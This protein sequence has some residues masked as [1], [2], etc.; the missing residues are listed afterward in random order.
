MLLPVENQMLVY[1]VA[2]Y[3]NGFIADDGC[4]LPPVSIAEYLSRRVLGRIDDDKPRTRAYEGFNGRPVGPKIRRQQFVRTY[5]PALQFY[6]RPVAVIGRLQLYD[7]IT[8][9][10]EPAVMVISCTGSTERW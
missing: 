2:E 8:G 6:R 9:L 7:F 4:Q 10:Y 3:E 1:F 5:K